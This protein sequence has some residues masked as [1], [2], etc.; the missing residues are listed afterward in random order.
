M[1]IEALERVSEVKKLLKQ[2]KIFENQSNSDI[3][4][5]RNI[6]NL[7][8]TIKKLKTPHT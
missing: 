3:F 1:A 6:E 5:P 8:S 2:E 7:L 4:S